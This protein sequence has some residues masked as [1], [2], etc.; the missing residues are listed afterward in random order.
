MIKNTP[1]S[2]GTPT[3]ILHWLLFI[4]VLFQ[5]FTAYWTMYVLPEKSPLAGLFIGKLHEPVGMLTLFVALL[6]II[7]YAL[8]IQPRFPNSMAHWE[9]HL[10]RAT[11]QLLLLLLI[12]MPLSGLFMAVA[13]GHAPNFFGLYQV[14]QF[15]QENKELSKLLFNIHVYSSY[16]LIA[17]VV[18]H[19][20]AA[21]KHYFV[22]RDNI[23]QRML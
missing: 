19:I 14:P 5:V 21:L 20:L 4:L 12:I 2:F 15:M 10:A 17:L 7:W 23:L 11:H 1:T 9:K 16:A 6:S 8:N 22:N 18:I 13:A 3:K